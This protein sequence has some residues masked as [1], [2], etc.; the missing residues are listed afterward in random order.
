MNRQEPVHGVGVPDNQPA[1][2][3]TAEA[4]APWRGVP[5]TVDE[6]RSGSIYWWVQP[7]NN[8]A[9][10]VELFALGNKVLETKNGL[11]IKRQQLE[12]AWWAPCIPPAQPQGFIPTATDRDT[13]CIIHDAAPPI[14]VGDLMR[15]LV[16]RILSAGCPVQSNECAIRGACTNKC[17][18]LDRGRLLKQRKEMT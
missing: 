8:K 12:G 1:Q 10:P 17:G 18:A 7:L 6:V 4:P 16:R 3:G 5:P 13:L 11:P 2:S 15:R 14:H 9:R